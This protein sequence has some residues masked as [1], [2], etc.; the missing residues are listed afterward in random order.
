MYALGWWNLGFGRPKSLLGKF[1]CRNGYWVRVKKKPSQIDSWNVFLDP[2]KRRTIT[3]CLHV[4]NYH[5]ALYNTLSHVPTYHL[6]SKYR[7]LQHSSSL[8]LSYVVIF[9]PPPPTFLLPY[10]T[11]LPPPAR[12]L[13]TLFLAFRSI[14]HLLHMIQ[15]PNPDSRT[16]GGN[17]KRGLGGGKEQE[18]ERE[19][20]RGKEV[21]YIHLG[22]EGGFISATD[23]GA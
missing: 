6:R 5:S 18:R 8:S 20:G 7:Y 14:V 13:P 22:G 15:I 21:S 12:D 17:G 1:S 10:H 2:P 9:P 16:G 4:N 19:R 3:I 23:Q 11:H